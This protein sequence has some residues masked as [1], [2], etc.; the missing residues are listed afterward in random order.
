VNEDAF[1]LTYELAR[2]ACF[3]FENWFEALVAVVDVVSEA[4]AL[5]NR[6]LAQLACTVKTE[7]DISS[8]KANP[9]G[10]I[11]GVQEPALSLRPHRP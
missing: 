8:T 11:E 7:V 9:V 1:R 10:E 2:V 5:R 4:E 6:S 3:I